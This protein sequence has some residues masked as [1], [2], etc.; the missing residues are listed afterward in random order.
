VEQQARDDAQREGVNAVISTMEAF[1]ARY[2]SSLCALL[3][4]S[5]EP[6]NWFWV[7]PLLAILDLSGVLLRYRKAE[8]STGIETTA[9]NLLLPLLGRVLSLLPV[10]LA[11]TRRDILELA[12]RCSQLLSENIH[13]IS[14]PLSPESFL[15][16]FGAL[17]YLMV[18]AQEGAHSGS[19]ASGAALLKNF[20]S[21]VRH[22]SREHFLAIVNLLLS[23][24]DHSVCNQGPN[25][26]TQVVILLSCVKHILLTASP[27][28]RKI[29][30]SKISRLASK[31]VLSFQERPSVRSLECAMEVLSLI[32]IESD[33]ELTTVDINLLLNAFG[34]LETSVVVLR[35]QDVQSP[36]ETAARLHNALH[37]LLFVLARHRPVLLYNSPTPFIHIIKSKLSF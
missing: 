18:T 29:L 2:L 32:A 36:T 37:Q 4:K 23:E 21:L 15:R 5:K 7:S 10:R 19:D 24:M 26:D 8:S 33:Y 35:D 20:D 34:V 28:K 12:S 27:S 1:A 17:Y 30:Q 16:I 6:G 25:H 3:A 11:S 31:V 13:D 9:A 22:S 14:P